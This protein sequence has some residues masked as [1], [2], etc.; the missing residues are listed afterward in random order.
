MGQVKSKTKQTVDVESNTKDVE[1]ESDK[2]AND[3]QMEPLSD[4][5]SRKGIWDT[6]IQLLTL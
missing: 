3:E 4:T 6:N 5:Q 1:V 2:E